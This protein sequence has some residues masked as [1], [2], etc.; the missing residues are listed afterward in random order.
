MIIYII[1]VQIETN[2]PRISSRNFHVCAF[3][4]IAYIFGNCFLTYIHSKCLVFEKI[5]P[6]SASMPFE[7]ARLIG[8]IPTPSSKSFHYIPPILQKTIINTDMTL[9]YQRYFI[10]T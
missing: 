7:Q 4:F 10:P 8:K 6:F 3:A 1:A 9:K 5:H 2:N